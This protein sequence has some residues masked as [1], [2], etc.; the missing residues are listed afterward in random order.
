MHIVLFSGSKK[1]TSMK[2]VKVISILIITIIS[3]FIFSGVE[4]EPLN[5][6]YKYLQSFIFSVIL[7]I[8]ILKPSLRLKLCYLGLLFIFLMITFYLFGKLALSNSFASIGIG[9]LL[10]V[11]LT[12]LPELV[13]K[14]YVEK[15]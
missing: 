15:L 3:F 2:A 8:S 1:I 11:S 10:I 4:F 5:Q 13:K 14:G 12:Y 7:A 9:I 6:T